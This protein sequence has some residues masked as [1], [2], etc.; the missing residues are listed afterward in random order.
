MI[1]ALDSNHLSAATLDVFRAEPLPEDH[2]FWDHPKIRI[3]PHV[4]S[5]SDPKSVAKLVAQNILRTQNGEELL[6]A[7]DVNKGY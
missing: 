2:P 1:A 6:Y 4:A 3:T 7:V 5:I